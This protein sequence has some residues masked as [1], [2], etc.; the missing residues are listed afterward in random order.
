MAF[1]FKMV[2]QRALPYSG[3]LQH[4]GTSEQLARWGAVYDAV[5]L[6]AAQREMLKAFR[7]RMN[8]LCL[9]GAW[10][11]DCVMTWRRPKHWR[12]IR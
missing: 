1:D 6:T 4:Y 12:P 7:R 5:T 10:C 3:Y 8:I 2:F 11:G 9:A